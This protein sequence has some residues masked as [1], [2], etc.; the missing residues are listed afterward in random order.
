MA[1]LSLRDSSC[2]APRSEIFS[3]FV[4]WLGLMRS[5]SSSSSPL[6]LSF[7]A[8]CFFLSS[9]RSV[10]L[11]SGLSL[12][13]STSSSSDSSSS[14]SSSELSELSLAASSALGDDELQDGRD[15]KA[16]RTVSVQQRQQCRSRRGSCL[17]CSQRQSRRWKLIVGAP[18]IAASSSLLL[19]L[20]CKRAL[21]T[22]MP[23]EH[24]RTHLFHEP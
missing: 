14:D 7:S 15:H 9:R 23:S 11:S 21:S 3:F 18:K 17:C 2:G 19:E 4:T 6:A 10:R 24:K 22:T 20:S 1:S 12:V 13:G 5:S 16:K 8:A